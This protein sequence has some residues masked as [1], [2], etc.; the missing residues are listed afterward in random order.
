MPT[1]ANRPGGFSSFQQ[2]PPPL[3]S[4][5]QQAALHQ[6]PAYRGQNHL[7]YQ[8]ELLRIQPGG[9]YQPGGGHHH[10]H[11]GHM[12]SSALPEAAA[13]VGVPEP[14]APLSYPLYQASFSPARRLPAGS[15]RLNLRPPPP[16][17]APGSRS[18]DDAD[19][20][21]Q[22]EQSVVIHEAPRPAPLGGGTL[23]RPRGTVKPRPVAKIIAKTRETI[24]SE[25]C[26]QLEEP[27]KPDFQKSGSQGE[28]NRL[29]VIRRGSRSLRRYFKLNPLVPDAHYSE[30]R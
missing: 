16:S 29:K 15:P 24:A 17:W 28:I 13:N 11:P 7:A 1:M 20:V 2:P 5:Q 12:H 4:L 19:I 22:A 6:E 21:Q 30:P 10:H 8:P 23:P 9:V 27:R 26:R 14:M 3:P 25:S 18:Y